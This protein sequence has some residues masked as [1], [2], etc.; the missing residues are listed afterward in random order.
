MAGR[1]LCVYAV[2]T[3]AAAADDYIADAAVYFLHK[4]I[5]LCNG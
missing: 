3:K 2:A 5:R 4:H 1:L